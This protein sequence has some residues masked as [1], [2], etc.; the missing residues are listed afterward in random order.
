MKKPPLPEPS[1]AVQTKL[2]HLRNR[3][4]ALDELILCMEQYRLYQIPTPKKQ[5]KAKTG[6]AARQLA[7]AA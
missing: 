4:A 3:K 1:G 6:G 2:A 5:G 7:G